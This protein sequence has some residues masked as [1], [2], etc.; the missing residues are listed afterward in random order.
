MMALITNMMI[1]TGL[2][3]IDGKPVADQEVMLVD[4]D[5]IEVLEVC[6]TDA[7]GHFAM[8][9]GT[10]PDGHAMSL[11]AKFR[12]GEIATIEAVHVSATPANQEFKIDL[13]TADLIAVSGK[14]VA[15][16]LKPFSFELTIDLKSIAGI[17]DKLVPLFNM[18]SRKSK[19]SCFHRRQITDHQFKV[20]VK[21]GTITLGGERIFTDQAMAR[22]PQQNFV[23]TQLELM[24][25]REKLAGTIYLG[26]RL[27]VQNPCSV[28]MLLEPYRED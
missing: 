24:P 5:N 11:L 22:H 13:H 20:L 23:A 8:E 16:K 3:S 14:A 18:A 1:L 9:C 17:P 25:N 12:Q 10:V 19:F 15:K 21:P 27:E 4:A 26:Y 28:E 7:A 2:L 6:K